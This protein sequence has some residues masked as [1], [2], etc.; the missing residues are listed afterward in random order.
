[1]YRSLVLG[2]GSSL[3]LL[4]CPRPDIAPPPAPAA[5]TVPAASLPQDSGPAQLAAAIDTAVATAME[6]GRLPGSAVVVVKDGAT[7]FSRGYGFADVA[8]KVAVDPDRTLFRIG[9]VS[10]AL[11]S[12]AITRLV[13]TDRL[14]L[15]T[16]VSTYVDSIHN[17]RGFSQPVTVRNLITHTAGFDQVGIGRQLGGFD[18]PLSERQA[19]RPSIGE[20]LS[21]D[22]NLRRVTAPGQFYRYDTYGIVLAGA[23]IERVTGQAYDVAMRSEMFEPLGMRSTFV[24]V[25]PSHESDLAVG[26]GF[27]DGEYVAQPYEVY[28]TTPASSIDTT[29]A[30]MGRLLEALTHDGANAHGRLLSDTATQAV[31][32]PQFRPHPEFVG[33][34]HGFSEYP[35]ATRSYDRPVRSVEHGGTVLGFTSRLTVLPELG[36][37]VF[38]VTNRDAEAGGGRVSLPKLVTE[39]ILDVFY[40]DDPPP[41]LPLP[42]PG[43]DHALSDYVGNYYYGVFCHSCDPEEFERGA[44]SRGKPRKVVATPGAITIDADEYLPRGGD[45]FVRRDGE[46]MAYFGRDDRGRVSFLVYSHN[47]NTFERIDD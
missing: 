17:P 46:R 7:I 1:M 29:P 43:P 21:T 10:K 32:A 40:D 28:L 23:I 11:T 8:E 37:G 15:D 25:D 18:L 39:A 19:G 16:D 36:L 27:V 35:S 38:I 20:F 5:P 42:Q 13:D 47:P 44:W 26:Y 34:T 3:A 41:P 2:L 6:E 31:L 45:V 12:L 30:D 9:S 22:R 14:A 4:G 33:I 24:E